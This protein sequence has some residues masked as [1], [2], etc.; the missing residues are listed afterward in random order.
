MDKVLHFLGSLT[1]MHQGPRVLLA[2]SLGSSEKGLN[3]ATAF[4]HGKEIS[5]PPPVF[6]LGEEGLP[7]I[8]ATPHP[9]PPPPCHKAQVVKSFRA[10]MAKTRGSDRTGLLLP[11]CGPSGTHLFGP[12]FAHL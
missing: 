6:L 3:P 9:C 8:M 2:E 11:A 10:R 5:P 7:E 4:S 1:E 12:Q